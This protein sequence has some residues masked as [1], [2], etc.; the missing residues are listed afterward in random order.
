MGEGSGTTAAAVAAGAKMTGIKCCRSSGGE[1]RC[2]KSSGG[3]SRTRVGA[4]GR[5]RR[6]LSHSGP[7]AVSSTLLHHGWVGEGEGME[8]MGGGEVSEV[9]WNEKG[10]GGVKVDG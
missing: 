10:V 2:Y 5:G 7:E 4:A 8:R 3:R 1:S 6:R 9:I